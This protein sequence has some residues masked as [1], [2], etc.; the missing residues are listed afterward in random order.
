MSYQLYR[1]TTLGTTLQDSLDELIS[2]QQISPDLA[3]KVLQQFDRSV[4]QALSQKAANR[5]T[6]KGHLKMYRF[7]DNVWTCVL[8][9]AEFRDSHGQESV[10]TQKIKI[11]ACDANSAKQ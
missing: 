9:G 6:F 5:Y 1:S 2:A 10:A 11:V 4:N 7:C 3:L 8:E